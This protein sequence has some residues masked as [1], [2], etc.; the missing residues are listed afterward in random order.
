[1]SK[2]R[3]NNEIAMLLGGRLA[4]ELIF[5]DYTSGASNDIERATQIAR[6]M[7]CSWGMSSTLGPIHYSQNAQSPFGNGPGADN[8]HYSEQTSQKID[9]EIGTIIRRN[10]DTARKILSDKRDILEKLSESLI[11]WETLDAKQINEIVA[12]GDIGIPVITDGGLKGEVKLE[13]KKKTESDD[14]PDTDSSLDLGGPKVS[15]A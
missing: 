8:S 2:D 10:Y 15:P 1:M 11:I 7:V 13:G 4:E 5:T 3:A 12:G 6:H 9:E 14:K